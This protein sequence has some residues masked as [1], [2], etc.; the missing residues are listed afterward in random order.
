[1]TVNNVGQKSYEEFVKELQQNGYK[2]T[3]LGANETNFEQYGN[4]LSDDLQQ[5]LICEALNLY[6]FLLHY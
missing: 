6:K 1:M 5:Q 3:S 4:A 2:T